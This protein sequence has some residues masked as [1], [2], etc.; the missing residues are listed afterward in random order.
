M[1]RPCGMFQLF[2]LVVPMS[3]IHSV[4]K[5]KLHVLTVY[6]C[7]F[8][9]FC[10]WNYTKRSLYLLDHGNIPIN[11]QYR[12]TWMWNNIQM[13]LELMNN[14]YYDTG[15]PKMYYPICFYCKILNIKG[16][17]VKNS[18]TQIRVLSTTYFNCCCG[19]SIE[20]MHSVLAC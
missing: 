11:I 20:V 4:F 2:S 8:F 1:F 6:S 18:I 9:K 17:I 7:I 10:Y 5:E 15:Y 14:L 12:Y 19:Y 13:K 16:N 3:M